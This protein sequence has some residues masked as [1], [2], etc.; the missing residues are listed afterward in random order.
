MSAEKTTST[1]STNKA[2]ITFQ[3]HDL[4]HFHLIDVIEHDGLQWL[5]STWLVDHATGERYPDKVVCLSVLP[6]QVVEHPHYR[7]VVTNPLPK[8]VLDG[9]EQVGYVVKRLP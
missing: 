2:M 7:Y 9:T 5:V 4:G 1:P 8:S 6:H 3:D